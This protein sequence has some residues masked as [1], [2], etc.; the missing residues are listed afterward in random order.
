MGGLSGGEVE[1]FA[2]AFPDVVS[3]GQVLTAA[4]V[5]ARRHPSW[6]ATDA[7]AFWSA[8]SDLLANGAVKNGPAG[9]FAAAL[10][11]FPTNP[12]FVAGAR[13]WASQAEDAVW[14]L[15]WERNRHFTG[16]E[17]ELS[18]LRARLIGD[19]R[20]ATA[21]QALHGL[22]GVGKTQLAVQ[23]AYRHARDYDLVWWIPAEDP[24]LALDALAALAERVGVAVS[25]QAEESAH[26]VVDLL[27]RGRRF[28]RWLVILDNASEPEDLYG[29]LSAAGG[30]GHVLVTTRNPAWSRLAGTVEVDVLPRS[31]AVSLLRARVSRLTT[32]EAGHIA[33]AVAD[34]PLALE[35][36]GAWLAET[37]TP[38]RDYL[39]LLRRRV[40]EVMARGTPSDHVPVAAA[41]TITLRTLDESAVLLARLW[42]QFGP[43]PIPVDLVRP[44]V[45]H[46]LPPPLDTAAR[47]LL[48]LRDT[49][50]TLVRTATV[51]LVA[52]DM[53]VM[54]RLV[55]AVLRGDTPD[56]LRPALRHIAGE[57]LARG[58]PEDRTT[59]DGWRRY[60]Q[61][62]P[63]VL[64][65]DLFSGGDEA[66]R[67]VLALAQALRDQGDY[68]T[69][70]RLAEHAH[71]RWVALLG[72]DHP[73]TIGAASNLAN[74]LRRL[75]QYPIAGALAEE[76]LSRRRRILGDDHPDTISAASDFAASLWRL[77]D[78]SAARV[79]GEDV[80]ARRQR[81]FGD[82][83]PDT[84]WA[85]G[86]LAATLRSLGDH[87]PARV[88]GE[89]VLGRRRRLLGDDHPD[90]LW[91]AG[92]LAETLRGLGDHSASRILA[93]DV[94]TRRQRLLGDDHPDTLWAE[95]TLAATLRS[96]GDYSAARALDEDVLVRWQRL[97][98]ED[99]PDT[100]SAAGNLAATLHHLGDYPTA[101]TLAED[102]LSRRQRILGEDHPDTISAKTALDDL[103]GG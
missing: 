19:G 41:W 29:L 89:D 1:A 103:D 59:P 33:A 6:A 85:A 93:V 90:T 68:A 63:H 36:A 38:A 26:A 67:V 77:G 5:P 57:L 37:G 54:H 58:H 32:A 8:V 75:G 80:L 100:I 23:Y 20:A 88:L 62:Y 84:L 64:A 79:L 97:L 96:L 17:A 3:A 21:P 71:R 4:G 30:G 56:V 45:A 76:V 2:D 24:T 70:R 83:H 52:G 34:L 86:S 14:S 60:A 82:D 9:L 87:P 43:E 91:A 81:I 74:T 65:V 35:Q 102:V 53:V 101:R 44:D 18:E 49:V 55:Q 95:G 99:H 40:S 22:G 92:S 42:A 78:Y 27:R 47:D 28:P 12:V 11:M 94:F 15:P 61:L 48:A 10:V 25:G 31:K 39:D 66:R 50:G 7:S 72:D 13:R 73:D 46:L 51:R 69:S 98:G 16:R